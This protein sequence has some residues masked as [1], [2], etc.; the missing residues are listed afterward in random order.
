MR[1]TKNISVD[2]III[3]EFE[4]LFRDVKFFVRQ[5]KFVT[6]QYNFNIYWI[7]HICLQ[8]SVKKWY[9]RILR[10]KQFENNKFNE[11]CQILLNRF[12][13]K[14]ESQRQQKQQIRVRLINIRR[15]KQIRI[16][17]KQA[18]EKTRAEIFACRRCSIKYSSNIQF[19][20]HVQEHYIKKIKIE[21]FIISISTSNITSLSISI[22][23]NH[24]TSNSSFSKKSLN[25]SS[26]AVILNQTLIIQVSITFSITFFTSSTITWAVITIKSIISIALSSTSSSNSSR[27]S[28]HLHVISNKLYM[29]IDNLFVMFAEKIKK[30]NSDII[31]KNVFFFVF[32]QTHIISYFKSIDSSKIKSIKFDVFVINFNSTSIKFFPIN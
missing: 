20:K 12:D 22:T 14:Y 18:E 25:I 10:K 23:Q 4:F 9:D 28:I 15:Q 32:R 29:I 13:K 7:I 24:K 17:K 21:I 19:Y 3:D 5:L 6:S 27:T 8:N 11:F 2:D 30:H 16:I 1:I 26:L 31:Q